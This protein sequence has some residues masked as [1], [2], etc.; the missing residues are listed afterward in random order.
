MGDVPDNSNTDRTD[1]LAKLTAPQIAAWY[2]RLA[3]YC[4]K[5]KVGNNEEVLSAKLM[6]Q[7]LKNRKREAKYSFGEGPQHLHNNRYVVAELIRHRRIYL[8]QEDLE[9][10]WVGI[11]P[12]IQG[13]GYPK[14]DGH[15]TINDM[16]LST[17]VEVPVEVQK[18]NDAVAIDLLYAFHGFQLY[19]KVKVKLFQVGQTSAYRV[20]FQEFKAGVNDYYHFNVLR[21][22]DCPNPDY[23]SKDPNA[24]SPKYEFI[25]VEHHNVTTMEGA[26][27]AAPFY[28]NFEWTVADSRVTGVG[29]VYANKVL[30]K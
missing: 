15:S 13:K 12:R 18:S 2:G 21:G 16:E 19:S 7:Y 9:G 24:V 10:K 25:H 14:W 22:V 20:F 29:I 26:N 11:V 27:L 17:L 23:N 1:P 30:Q 8:T 3:D 6:R 4:S 28:E 5:L